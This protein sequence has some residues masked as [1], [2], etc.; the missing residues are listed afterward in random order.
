MNWKKLI[1]AFEQ[2]GQTQAAFCRE[3]KLPYSGFNKRLLQHRAKSTSMQEATPSHY[4]TLSPTPV[5]TEPII[6]SYNSEVELQVPITQLSAVLEILHG[7]AAYE[8]AG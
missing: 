7:G 1:E 4:I 3:H 6:I 8:S 5:P 2:S